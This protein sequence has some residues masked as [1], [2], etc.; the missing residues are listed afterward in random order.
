MDGIK[1]TLYLSS[2]DLPEIKN[3]KV[4]D[5]YDLIVNVK[6]VGIHQDSNQT[7]T[8]ATFEINN[9]ISAEKDPMDLEA[10]NGMENNEEFMQAASGRKAHDFTQPK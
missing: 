2:K 8:T 7:N 6:M 10:I 4:G 5:S 9:A 1:P 3:W